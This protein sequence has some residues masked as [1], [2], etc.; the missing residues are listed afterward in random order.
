M[1]QMQCQNMDALLSMEQHNTYP[2]M[3]RSTPAELNS[4]SQIWRQQSVEAMHR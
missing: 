2:D 1:M 3:M 4:G